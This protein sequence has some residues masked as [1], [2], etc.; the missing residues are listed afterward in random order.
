MHNSFSEEEYQCSKYSKIDMFYSLRFHASSKMW[1]EITLPFPNVDG[2]T[3]KAREWISNFI[4]H[5]M[6]YVITYPCWD[7]SWSMSVK[8]VTGSND[9]KLRRYFWLSRHA[10]MHVCRFQSQSDNLINPLNWTTF[11]I[12][13]ILMGTKN[14]L[15]CWHLFTFSFVS[16]SLMARN[17]SIVD[18]NNNKKTFVA[19]ISRN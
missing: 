9:S 8:G 4:S 6:T 5:F 15:W 1:S 7:S 2:S 19:A 11:G 3:V 16:I 12:A 17:H 10:I 18:N 13:I 14:R